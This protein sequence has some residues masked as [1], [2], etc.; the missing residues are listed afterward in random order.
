MDE[1]Q[2]TRN[3]V[4]ENNVPIYYFELLNAVQFRMDYEWYN[5]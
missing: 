2:V 3:I 1:L 5:L 4:E